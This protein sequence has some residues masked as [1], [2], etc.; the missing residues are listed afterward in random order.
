MTGQGLKSNAGIVHSTLI[1]FC[2]ALVIMSLVGC[3]DVNCL[4][5]SHFTDDGCLKEKPDS[6]MILTM[7]SEVKFFLEASGSMNGLYRP[8][9]Q[10]EFRDDVYQIVSYYLSDKDLVYTLCSDN[11]KSGFQMSLR[12][13]ANAIKVQGFPTMGTTS[14]T[15]MI[16]T[17]ISN[18]DTLKN[19]VGVLISD[20][21][22]DP[23]GKD[24][25]AY[26]LGM[27]TTKISHITSE[28]NMAFSLVAATSKYYDNQGGV[29]ADKSPYYF[30]IMGKPENVAKVRDDISTMLNENKSFVD[31]IETGMSYGGPQFELEKVRNCMKMGKQPTFRD[32]DDDSPCRIK[33]KLH[34]ENYRWLMSNEEV[35][36]ST[37]ECKMIHGSKVEIDSIQIDSLYK[38]SEHRL[39]R[40]MTASIYMSISNLQA[41]CDVLEWS[42]NPCKIDNAVG[43]FNQF[44]GADNWKQFNK[45]YSIEN[46]LQGLFRAAHLSSCSKKPNYVLISTH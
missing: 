6:S 14:I 39:N 20:M 40:S 24:N 13:F 42:F 21:K 16:E 15:D 44:F 4:P 22:F 23:N 36:R 37:F 27:Y 46:F 32:V 45:T 2:F 41:D 43:E 5:D 3:H 31:N 9:C 38:D 1:A 10:T 11:G 12:D 35:V 26:Q 7:P 18:I 28:S 25:I 19:Q 33:L 30:L 29:I 8:G 34:L 17:V